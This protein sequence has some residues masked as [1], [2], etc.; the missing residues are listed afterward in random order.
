MS[1]FLSSQNLLFFLAGLLIV[2]VLVSALFPLATKFLGS[3][4]A[5]ILSHDLGKLYRLLKKNPLPTAAVFSFLVV[6]LAAGYFFYLSYQPLR[7]VSAA[8]I[9]RERS[10]KLRQVQETFDYLKAGIYLVDV[11][12]R[13]AFAKDRLA[14][15][16]NIP[17]TAASIEVLAIPK[18][19]IFVYGEKGKF[20]LAKKIAEVLQ[21]KR[22]NYENLGKIYLVKDGYEGLVKAGLEVETGEPQI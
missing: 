14:G 7:T 17:E 10:A 9:V 12:D 15:S 13:E 20:A 5:R 11:R 4:S 19:D 16:V 6:F 21:K 3:S 1:D 22:E 2:T 8:Q 18:T